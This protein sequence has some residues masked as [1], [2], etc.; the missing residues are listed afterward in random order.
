MYTAE[1]SRVAKTVRNYGD[2]EIVEIN[3]SQ[4]FVKSIIT[5]EA[6]IK[7]AIVASLLD[8]FRYELMAS[9]SPCA[10]EPIDRVLDSLAAICDPKSISNF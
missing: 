8:E 5:D 1:L 9:P 3:G 10:Q 7:A 4:W 2:R 6:T